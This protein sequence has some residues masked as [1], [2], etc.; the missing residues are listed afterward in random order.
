MALG[1]DSSLKLGDT[2][3]LGAPLG[4]ATPL[5]AQVEP[6]PTTSQRFQVDISKGLGGVS[7]T[8]LYTFFSLYNETHSR[9]ASDGNERESL[10]HKKFSPHFALPSLSIMASLPSFS[11]EHFP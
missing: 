3:G 11:F 1:E 9:K 4:W 2:L 8:K 10:T 5:T 6:R 7:V